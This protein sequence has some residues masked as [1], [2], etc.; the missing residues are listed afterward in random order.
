MTTLAQ[1][2]EAVYQRFVTQWA[3]RTPF[4]FE[5]EAYTP[6]TRTA[7]IHVSM[8][9]LGPSD[10][11]LGP[12]GG[13]KFGRQAVIVGTVR[14]PTDTGRAVSDG[15]AKAFLDIF[16]GRRFGGVAGNQGSI[17]EQPPAGAWLPTLVLIPC[18]YEE[19]K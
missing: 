13:R 7:Y 10:S 19:T 4:T 14:S 2:R 15:H 3:N 16:E 9:N 5:N 18:F 17:Q 6:P 12:D 1:A 8:V 11:T